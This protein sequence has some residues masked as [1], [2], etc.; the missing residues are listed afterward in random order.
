MNKSNLAFFEDY[1]SSF[2]LIGKSSNSKLE[3]FH[4]NVFKDPFR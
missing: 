1:K 4:L 2:V 3:L